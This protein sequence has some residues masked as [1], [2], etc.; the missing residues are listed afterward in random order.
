[1]RNCFFNF[2]SLEN[3]MSFLPI[4]PVEYTTTHIY[5]EIKRERWNAWRHQIFLNSIQKRTIEGLQKF[6]YLMSY[7]IPYMVLGFCPGLVGDVFGETLS[8]NLK[9][10]LVHTIQR[11]W[12]RVCI[13][14]WRYSCWIGLVHLHTSYFPIVQDLF[15]ISASGYKMSMQRRIRKDP[16]PW[17]KMIDAIST[18]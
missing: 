4:I 17:Y 7:I 18:R 3:R 10:N 13:M 6:S 1:M 2:K 11:N 15:E 14:K 16:A 9:K 12:L 5:K 8:L